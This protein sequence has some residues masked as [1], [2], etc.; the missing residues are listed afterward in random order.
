MIDALKSVPTQVWL[1]A[2]T[3]F[4]VFMGVMAMIMR[5]KAA[6]KPANPKKIMIPPL[7]MSSG[8]LMYIFPYF[9]LTWEHLWITVLIGVICSTILIKTS[10]FEVIGKDIFLK[11]SKA[12]AI[13][14]VGLLVFRTAAKIY[15]GGTFH[16][17]E[18]GG[19]FYMLA[20]SML[21]PWRLA[22][23]VQFKKLQKQLQSV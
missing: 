20:Y 22:M 17:G 1:I 9:R 3:V 18:L 2:S 7:A 21:L 12:F 16:L 4:I 14:L 10:K 5:A 6:K 13:V 11:P 15:L 8:A 19:I 23:L